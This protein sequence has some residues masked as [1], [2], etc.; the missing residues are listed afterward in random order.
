MVHNLGYKGTWSMALLGFIAL[1][2]AP[3][4][5]IFYQVGARLRAMS[6]FNPEL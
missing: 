2:L 4:P 1:G 5:L 6:K 3:I